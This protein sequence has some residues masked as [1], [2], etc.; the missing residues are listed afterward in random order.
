[1]NMTR[2]QFIGRTALTAGALAAAETIRT[3]AA[4]LGLPIGFQVYPIR[5]MLAKDFEAA[6]AGWRRSAIKA[7]RCARRPAM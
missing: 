2:R 1:M 7:S 5:E 3:S 6:C 4:P